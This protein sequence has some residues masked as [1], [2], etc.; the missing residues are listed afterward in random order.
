MNRPADLHAPCAALLAAANVCA[1]IRS[2]VPCNAGGNNRTYRLETSAGV[3]AVKQYF[4]HEGDTRDRLAAEFDFL[5]YAAK[6]APGMAPAPL[7]KSAANGL[8]LFEFIEGCPYQAG[9]IAWEHVD[10]AAR[11]FRAL[12]DPVARMEAATLPLASE[13]CFSITEHLNLIAARLDRLRT[14]DVTSNEDRAAQALTTQIHARWLELKDEVSAASRSI[15][16]DPAAHLEPAQRCISPSDFGFHNALAQS[17]GTPRFLDFEYAGWDDPAK[18]TGDFFAQLAVP[19]PTDLFDR[20][21]QEA[22]AALP[23][24]DELAERARLLRPVYQ[25]KWCCIALNVFLPVNL[26]RRKFADPTLDEDALKRA[27]LAKAATLFQSIATY[28]HGLY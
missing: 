1:S 28:D 20:F 16:P 21:V 7:A 5:V 10:S 11:F 13:A 23:R 25:V 26:A 12:N 24:P 14:V 4:R 15:G 17:D 22:S 27:Q 8:A 3:F 19:V 18:M 2:L 9:E 6:A